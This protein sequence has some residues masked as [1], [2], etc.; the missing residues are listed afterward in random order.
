MTLLVLN[1]VDTHWAGSR[2]D[3]EE[4]W[5]SLQKKA[6][7]STDLLKTESFFFYAKDDAYFLWGEACSFPK[8]FFI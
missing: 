6:I 1:E 7:F 8:C 4:T 2:W 5:L 3:L